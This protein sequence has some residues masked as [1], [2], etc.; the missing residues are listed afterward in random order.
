MIQFYILYDKDYNI[1]V[2]DETS[3]YNFQLLSEF[4]KGSSYDVFFEEGKE[5]YNKLTNNQVRFF[6][7]SDGSR[8][9]LN[10]FEEEYYNKAEFISPKVGER[11]LFCINEYDDDNIYYAEA[12]GNFF[13]IKEIL[14]SV[15]GYGKWN[16]I[17]ESK[18]LSSLEDMEDFVRDNFSFLLKNIK[19]NFYMKNNK[20]S[21]FKDFL[22]KLKKDYDIFG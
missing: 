18:Y 11:K 9:F 13:E 10:W 5:I 2:S 16:Y 19:W 12:N 3:E 6:E 1:F 21:K 15:N 7:D 4:S 20:N 14:Y 17:L 8:K 22:F